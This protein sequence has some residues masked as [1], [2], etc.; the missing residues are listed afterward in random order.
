MFPKNHKS[1]KNDGFHVMSLL[2]YF[3]K[4]AKMMVVTSHN[5]LTYSAPRETDT[6]DLPIGAKVSAMRRWSPTDPG[7]RGGRERS[8]IRA[9]ANPGPGEL[10][11]LSVLSVRSFVC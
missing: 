7:A 6:P 11:C 1:V 8:L 2:P 10:A 9:R 3:F 4:N 5:A